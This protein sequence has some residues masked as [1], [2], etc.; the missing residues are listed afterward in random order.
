[1]GFRTS[2]IVVSSAGGVRSREKIV[3]DWAA[4]SD[5]LIEDLR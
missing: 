1:V 2:G 4:P 3:W 5:R